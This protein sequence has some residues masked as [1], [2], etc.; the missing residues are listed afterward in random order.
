MD[1]VKI[2][3]ID[4]KKL[5]EAINTGSYEINL[6]AIMALGAAVTQPASQW[7]SCNERLP[8]KN[9]KYY[10]TRLR[11]DVY[12]SQMTGA[13]VRETSYIWYSVRHKRWSTIANCKV[14]A[15]QLPPEPWKGE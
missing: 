7:V 5:I 4:S 13:Y 12:D 6:S 14:V 1:D 15:W 9:G 11:Y 2:H 8:E 3:V 10:V